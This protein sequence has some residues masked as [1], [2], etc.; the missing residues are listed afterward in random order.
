FFSSDWHHGLGEYDVFRA[1]MANNRPTT[2]YHMGNGINSDRDDIGFIFDPVTSKGYVVS[3]RIGG[4][5][6]EDIYRVARA[7]ANPILLVQ[8]TQ[9]G[10]F[11]PGA[12]V[13]FSGCGGQTYTTDAGGRYVLQPLAGLNCDIVISATGFQ[14]VRI[15]VQSLQ[16]DAQNVVRVSLTPAGGGATGGPLTG[17]VPG[18]PT[19]PGTYRGI[20][21]NGQTGAAIPQANVQITQRTTGAT[22][23]VLT[24]VNGAYIV[25]LDPYNTYDMV[26]SAPGYE[27]ARFPI[28][29]NDGNDPNILGNMT[30]IPGG[31]TS[32]GGTS[33]GGTF[34][35]VNGF[36]VQLASLSKQPDL[37]KFD[38]VSS[39]GRVYDVNTG[40][41]YKVRLGVYATR[42]EAAAAAAS[43]KGMG[44]PGA[45]VVAD[46]GT[47]AFAQ[48]G[49]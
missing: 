46:N 42:A 22:A 30:L 27:T 10:S 36:A 1:E 40:S 35:Q 3:N 38:G 26:V 31:G 48:A 25:A 6:Q 14:P 13:D 32:G 9:D 21:T 23:T 49:G 8:S 5:G 4:S 20:V 44:Y 37:G 15:P 45:F 41:A 11:L 39:L 18:G 16:P 29:N 2:L 17:P 43:A 28:T 34:T 19:P 33:G 47:S 12:A 7:A 24:N